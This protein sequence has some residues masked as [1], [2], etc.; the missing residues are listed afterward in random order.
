[1]DCLGI[2]NCY[3]AHKMGKLNSKSILV[4]Y[5]SSIIVVTIRVLLFSDVF[6]RWS[7]NL[8]VIGLVTLPTF[9]YAIVGLSLV[10]CNVE[11]VI[12]FRIIELGQ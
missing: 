6:I 9:L 2:Y 1:L 12:K 7:P 10:M 8:Y 3:T 4:F 11:L 5:C